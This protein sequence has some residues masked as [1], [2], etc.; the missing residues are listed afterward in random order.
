MWFV[1]AGNI[2][3]LVKLLKAYVTKGAG[4]LVESQV[5]VQVLGVCRKLVGSRANDQYGF[6]LLT[7][8][9]EF[10]P[11]Y[12]FF[13]VVLSVHL[14]LRRQI[15]LTDLRCLTDWCWRNT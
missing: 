4:Y 6:E 8:V 10:V 9:F 15:F 3:A 11:T 5:L 2:P 1:T 7:A 12:V 13:V 14:S